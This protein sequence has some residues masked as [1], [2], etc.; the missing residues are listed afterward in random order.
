MNRL[1]AL[2]A[3]MAAIVW[4]CAG[5]NVPKPDVG[6]AILS[7]DIIVVARVVSGEARSGS[8]GA[9]SELLLRIVRTL[10]GELSPGS[11]I[12]IK[13]SGYRAF[14]PGPGSAMPRSWPVEPFLALW[15]LKGE[16]GRY[17]VVPVIQ[18]SGEPDRASLVLP[19]ES[20][21]ASASSDAIAAVRE[22]ILAQ[23]RAM[24]IAGPDKIKPTYHV[25]TINGR[26]DRSYGVGIYAAKALELSE[27]LDRLGDR[28]TLLAVYRDAASDMSPYLRSIGITG[29]IVANDPAGPKQAAE[30]FRLLFREAYVG[31][32]AA[33]LVGYR[34]PADPGAI[35]AI[36][37]LATEYRDLDMP[38]LEW[39]AAEALNAIHTKDAMPW[40]IALLDSADER[41]GGLA[42][43]G[44][45]LFVRN[46]PIVT[47]ESIPTQSWRQ[48]REP[49]PFRTKETDA[50]CWSNPLPANAASNE[51][52][53]FWKL[54]WHDHGVEALK[55]GE[56]RPEVPMHS[57]PIP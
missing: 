9:S 57:S 5:I 8:T 17:S 20:H 38:L 29:L 27:V 54:W 1:S 11:Q 56:S 37:R 55:Q 16:Q 14:I 39:S 30:E 51:Y 50:H 40:M 18:G 32:I 33:K 7:C 47:P 43:N 42:L 21:G 13:T 19:E 6:Q 25:Q 3:A 12:A 2:A 46:S 49:T 28:P 24:A 22:E 10:K 36:G 44:I 53:K 48:S 15:F 4:P 45:C 52:K 34:N 23:L 35:A 31:G 41:I 26:V